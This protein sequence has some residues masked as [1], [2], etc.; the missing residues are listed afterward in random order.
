[1]KLTLTNELNICCLTSI[2]PIF[3][4]CSPDF[5]FSFKAF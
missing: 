1:M 3:K 2:C 4:I 5:G